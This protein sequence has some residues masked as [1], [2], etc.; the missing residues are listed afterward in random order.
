MLDAEDDEAEDGGEEGE[1]FYAAC[2]IRI[3]HGDVEHTGYIAG[4]QGNGDK[5]I[6]QGSE[7]GAAHVDRDGANQEVDGKGD[8]KVCN[9]IGMLAE[10]HGQAP[11]LQMNRMFCISY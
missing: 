6:E 7:R 3:V 5:D 2:R 10:F 9:L 8:K 4:K 1:I 11:P